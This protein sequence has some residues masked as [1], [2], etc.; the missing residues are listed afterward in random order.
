MVQKLIATRMHETAVPFTSNVARV[1]LIE[2]RWPRST[3]QS[4]SG[5][6]MTLTRRQRPLWSPLRW[7]CRPSVRAAA[8]PRFMTSEL[9]QAARSA[10]SCHFR[11]YQNCA[12]AVRDQAVRARAPARYVQNNSHH[13]NGDVAKV[14]TT[15][16]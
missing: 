4:H 2:V 13:A 16:Y 1:S 10:L 8:P 6:G 11:S 9:A 7:E 5:Q 3:R 14:K 15:D 12:R